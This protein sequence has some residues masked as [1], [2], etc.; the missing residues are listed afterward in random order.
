MSIVIRPAAACA[1]RSRVS[2]RERVQ[3]NR[4]VRVAEDLQRLAAQNARGERCRR[5]AR[6]ADLRDPRARSGDDGG[7]LERQAPTARR[8][9]ASA[10]RLRN[11]RRAARRGRRRRARPRRRRPSSQ[12]ALEAVRVSTGGDDTPGTE[13]LRSLDGD[14]ADAARGAEHEHGLAGADRSKPGQRHPGGEADDAE[15]CGVEIVGVGGNLDEDL[16]GHR[17]R[18]CERPVGDDPEPSA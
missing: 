10:A 6:V 7:R 9:R 1:S 16:V 3:R 12:R 15:R 11:S 2:L 8:R 5:P 18:L 13:D 17:E 4:E 14:G